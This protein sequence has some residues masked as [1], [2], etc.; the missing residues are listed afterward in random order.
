MY[1]KDAASQL[2]QQFWTAFG[3]YIAPH[4]SADGLKVNWVN[5]KTGIKHLYFKM[6]ADKQHAFI[7][8]EMA[9]PDTEIQEM[10]F[11]HFKAYKTL[12]EASLNE[13]WQWQLHLNDNNRI[14]SRI[15]TE[16]NNVSV[17]KQTDWPALI[18][19]FKPRIIALDEF[20]SDA[21]YGFDLFK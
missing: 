2:K 12:L 6:E 9:Q 13:T 16:L 21:Q 8:I 11:D 3:Q 15:Y 1:S 19:F 10:M 20:W 4:P 14:V 7:A 17:F 5:Y 18:S